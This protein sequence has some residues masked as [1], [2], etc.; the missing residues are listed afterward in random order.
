MER[1]LITLSYPIIAGAAIFCALIN[2]TVDLESIER[3]CF[4]GLVIIIV[5]PIMNFN[6]HQNRCVLVQRIACSK[7]CS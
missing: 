3:L 7:T 5:G 1:R 6:P 2:R 4:N